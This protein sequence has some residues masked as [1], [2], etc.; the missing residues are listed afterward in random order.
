MLTINQDMDVMEIQQQKNYK[1]K[2]T[3]WTLQL[4]WQWFNKEILTPLHEKKNK[5]EEELK[6][7]KQWIDNGTALPR[8][9]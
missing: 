8:D 3:Q 2:E 4:L 6:K 7:V 9:E 5:I 1:W